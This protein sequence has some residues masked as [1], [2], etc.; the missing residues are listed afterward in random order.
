MT[1]TRK[2]LY[3]LAAVVVI[4]T[5][6]EGVVQLLESRAAPSAGR[7]D[8]GWQANF[9]SRHFDWHEPDPDLLWR[10]RPNLSTDYIETNQDR[11]IGAPVTKSKP[12][13]TFRVLLLGDSSPVGLGLRS[14]RQAFG[15]VLTRL[16][17]EELPD[18]M[19]VDLVNAAVAGYTSEQARRWFELYGREF[20]PDLIVIY[21]GNND[22]SVSG[23]VPD[24]ELLAAQELKG[25][26]RLLSK[27]ALYRVLRNLLID[28]GDI[29]A[30]DPGSLVVRVSAKR[31]GRNVAR[32]VSAAN[33]GGVPVV[34]VNPIVPYLW[35]AGLQF[36]VFEQMRTGQGELLLP[37]PMRQILGR[38][39]KYC[40][41]WAD[42]AR[43]YGQADWYTKAVHKSAFTDNMSPE[44]AVAYYSRQLEAYPGEPVVINNVG[45]SLWQADRVKEARSRLEEAVGA[46]EKS[47][48]P[49]RSVV[50]ASAGGVFPYNLAIAWLS[51]GMEGTPESDTTRAVEL[52]RRALRYDYF[53][54]RIKDKYSRALRKC[55]AA[56]E[57]KAW[58]LVRLDSAFGR[59]LDAPLGA[60]K[61]FIDHCHPTADGHRR[62]AETVFR[63]LLS[64]GWVP[65][66][67]ED[68]GSSE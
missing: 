26:R 52:L 24:A 55:L 28:R 22:A 19:H 45:V 7:P 27:L 67:E 21:V 57:S 4:L 65:E 40:I 2:L 61:M 3:S 46:F 18:A 29:G 12:T 56:V 36:K 50:E 42:F 62:I 54:L 39:V 25:L 41:D 37:E 15:Q 58:S 64:R 33:R 5:L 53:S 23:T 35:P 66:R 6:T 20:D 8:V 16:V 51:T 49:P 17:Q 11:L 47:H 43:R 34:V 59:T 31:Y 68:T 32:I 60:E 14:Y 38:R 10:F 9:F 13:N 44:R 48:P 30:S 1:L 63:H